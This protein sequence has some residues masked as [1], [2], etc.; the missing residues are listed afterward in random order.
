M[1]LA[2]KF[3]AKRFYLSDEDRINARPF[4]RVGTDAWPLLGRGL[5]IFFFCVVRL[6][7]LERIYAEMREIILEALFLNNA[8]IG[9]SAM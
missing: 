9:A 7:V 5:L 6:S 4:F 3:I 8:E 1:E 2:A